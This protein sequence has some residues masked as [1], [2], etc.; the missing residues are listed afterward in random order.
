MKNWCERGS[1]V[2][3]QTAPVTVEWKQQWVRLT[4]Q[5]EEEKCWEPSIF[6]QTQH[7]SLSVGLIPRS[8]RSVRRDLCSPE[9]RRTIMAPEEVDRS[10]PPRARPGQSIT[11]NNP[12]DYCKITDSMRCVGHTE[13]YGCLQHLSSQHCKNSVCVLGVCVGGGSKHI[14]ETHQTLTSVIQFITFTFPPHLGG[15][16]NVEMCVW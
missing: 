3:C 14:K 12:L 4:S 9:G 6:P 7:S 2:S 10:I 8:V 11:S 16:A 1:S 15:R 13:A 5:T